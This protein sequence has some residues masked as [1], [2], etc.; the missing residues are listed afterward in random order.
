MDATRRMVALA[1]N[2]RTVGGKA[3]ENLDRQGGNLATYPFVLIYKSNSEILRAVWTKSMRTFEEPKGSSRVWKSAADSAPAAASTCILSSAFSHYIFSSSIERTRDYK[4]AWKD[5]GVRFCAMRIVDSLI[6]PSYR[7]WLMSNP[8]QMTTKKMRVN[9]GERQ[10][11]K[12]LYQE[13]RATLARTR[14][15]KI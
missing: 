2:T 4:S 14:W 11:S 13:W 9:P 8:Q 5:D 3:L 1:E 10:S 7:R 15:M 6:F 12:I